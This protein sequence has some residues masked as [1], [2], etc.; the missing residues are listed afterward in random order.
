MSYIDKYQKSEKVGTMQIRFNRCRSHFLKF[1]G[2]G[3]YDG[4]FEWC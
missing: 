2:V 4:K 1:P 3:M